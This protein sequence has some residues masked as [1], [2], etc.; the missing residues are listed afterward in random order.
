[1]HYYRQIPKEET[2][3]D[4]ATTSRDRKR[5]RVR[6]VTNQRA[7]GAISIHTLRHLV[8][9]TEPLSL[10]NFF[11]VQWCLLLNKITVAFQFS[12]FS[13]SWS[14]NY[15]LGFLFIFSTSF[16]VKQYRLFYI[17]SS[18]T[19]NPRCDDIQHSRSMLRVQYWGKTFAEICG[20][21]SG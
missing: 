21:V 3:L 8:R 5:G 19:V 20:V 10:M 17:L 15:V 14:H 18:T 7:T 2:S 16:S 12:G 11:R 9:V 6:R 13:F 4:Y 1:M